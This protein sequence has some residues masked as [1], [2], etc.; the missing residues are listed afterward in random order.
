MQDCTRQESASD[1]PPLIHFYGKSDIKPLIRSAQPKVTILTF[2]GTNCE[3]D[4]KRAFVKAGADADIMILRNLTQFQLDESIREMAAKIKNSQ[5][6]MLPGGFS[7]GDE[8]D[9]SAKFI[10]AVFRNP[11]IY[12]KG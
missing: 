12:E 1:Q 11:L 2:P 5:I 10:T 6:L 3:M 8:P 4:S 9:G 7:G